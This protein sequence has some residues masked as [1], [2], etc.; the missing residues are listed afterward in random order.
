MDMSR[1]MKDLLSKRSNC[2]RNSL[3]IPD[4]SKS[5]HLFFIQAFVFC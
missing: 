3:K 1:V 2:I 4:I 5:T